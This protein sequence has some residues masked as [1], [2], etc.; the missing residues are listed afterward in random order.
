[1][2]RFLGS[3]VVVW[4]AAFGAIAADP[5]AP[6]VPPAA[7]AADASVSVSKVMHANP[8]R[9]SLGLLPGYGNVPRIGAVK[10]AILDSGFAGLGPGRAYLPDSAVVVEHYDPAFVRKFNLGDPE[11]RKPFTPGDAHGRQLAQLVWAVTGGSAEGPKFYLLNANG[12]TL[13]RRAVRVAIEEKVDI[14]LFAGTFEGAGNYDGRGPVNAAVDDAVNAG[15]IWINAAGNCG[16]MVYNGPVT[17]GPG[18]YVQ[19]AGGSTALRLRN[20]LDE[21]TV[22]VILTWNDYK[23]V[24]DAG[25]DKDLDLFVE[26]VHGREIGKSTLKQVPGGNGAVPGES[27]NPRERVV[28]ADLAAVPATS[29]YRIRVKAKAGNFGPRDRLRVMVTSPKPGPIP[30]PETGKPVQPVELLDASNSGEIYPPADH[31]GVLTVGEPGRASAIGPTADGRAK[32]D[33]ILEGSVARF[34]SGEET[35]G[36]SNA[37]AY[38]AGVVAVLKA[39][40]PGLTTGHVREWVRLL[41]GRPATSTAPP[42]MPLPIRKGVA[43]EVILTPGQERALRIAVRTADTE[44]RGVVV[45]GP[46]G[47]VA[48][49]RPFRPILPPVTADP[50]RR[51]P[52][53]HAPWRTPPPSALAMLVRGQQ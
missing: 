22:T 26:D 3:Y 47:S 42:P 25:T 6:T 2:I 50:S 24:E 20:R 9:R 33:L 27:K 32:P 44:S 17:I 40:E 5:P 14:I 18:D 10:V 15:I 23:H 43:V 49:R 1:M 45:G 7:P 21:N 53:L 41:D 30:D 19:F 28:L 29:E 37:S 8:I 35:E 51:G 16:G 36:S 11:F 48:V 34:T 12:P 31:P 4:A 39:T 46:F 52:P 38:F 13:F